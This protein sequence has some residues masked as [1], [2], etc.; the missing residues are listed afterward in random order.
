[1][2]GAWFDMDLQEVDQGVTS[3]LALVKSHAVGQRPP[4][5]PLAPRA[6]RCGHHLPGPCTST[7][8]LPCLHPARSKSRSAVDDAAS[9]GAAGRGDEGEPEASLCRDTWTRHDDTAAASVSRPAAIAEERSEIKTDRSFGPPRRRGEETR[10][11][12]TIP[13]NAVRASDE[14]KRRAEGIG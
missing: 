3:C 11:G 9:D 1:M 13:P 7:P 5:G 10:S 6:P 4:P 12:G 14:E 8:S 2:T